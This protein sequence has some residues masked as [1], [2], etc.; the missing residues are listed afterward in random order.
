MGRNKAWF[1]QN[2][3]AARSRNKRRGHS[4]CADGLMKSWPKYDSDLYPDLRAK[5][6]FVPIGTKILTGRTGDVWRALGFGGLIGWC[7]HR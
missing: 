7:S 3:D 6:H 5:L 2:L 4:K 1:T